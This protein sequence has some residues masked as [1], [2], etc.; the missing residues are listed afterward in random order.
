MLIRR[1]F[2][3]GLVAFTLRA[4]SLVDVNGVAPETGVSMSPISLEIS[5]GLPSICGQSSS[6]DA[7]TE[8]VFE[9]VEKRIEL[10]FKVSNEDSQGLRALSRSALES[11]CSA[12][13]CTI[14]HHEPRECFDSYILSES[15]LF[16]F[17]DRV[18][19]KTC[20]TTLPLG[21]VPAIIAAAK[22]LGLP[23]LE[24]TYSRGSFMFPE[25]QLS[26]HNDLGAEFEY[27]N[28]FEL[29]GV[30]STDPGE[31]CLLGSPDGS[32]WLVHKKRFVDGT[33]SVGEDRKIMVDCIMTG[34]S[35]KAR[36]IYFKD[37][38]ISELE[39]ETA[40]TASLTGV[41]PSFHIKGKCF[42]PCGYSCNAHGP[43]P[44]DERYF[45]V[46]ITPEEGF[47]YASVEAVF[48]ET[49]SSSFSSDI[50]SFVNRV[51]QVFEPLSV[52]VTVLAPAGE[53]PEVRSFVDLPE[54][55]YRKVSEDQVEFSDKY[56]SSTA[57]CVVF[58]RMEAHSEEA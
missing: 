24:M 43:Q 36:S 9:G 48:D 6:A 56:A 14:I 23:A 44:G 35:R 4:S 49:S 2:L 54:T 45:T 46:H 57:S 30:L 50:E 34:L 16:V 40:M 31:S 12:S 58:R 41:Q 3:A 33:E 20:G 13:R 39:N 18:M 47:S 51:V 37:S 26:P 53:F 15:S 5:S 38:S 17:R 7:D 22:E 32:Y 29:D 25:K 27:L 1:L 42:D 21:G 8:H 10:F 19:I 55:L 52:K 11:V 28:S